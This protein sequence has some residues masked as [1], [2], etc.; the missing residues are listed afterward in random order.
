MMRRIF[1][2]PTEIEVTG[3]DSKVSGGSSAQTSTAASQIVLNTSNNDAIAVNE[4]LIIKDVPGYDQS[5]TNQTP[6]A[7]LVLVVVNRDPATGRPVCKAVNGSTTTNLVPAITLPAAGGTPVVLARSMRALSEKQLRTDS[8]TSLPTKKT[9]YLQKSACEVEA[10]TFFKLAGK[11]VELN[12]SDITERGIMEFRRENN[13]AYWKGVQKKLVLSNKYRDVAE[14]TYFTPGIFSQIPAGNE[15]DFGGQ[16][17][18]P[19]SL[20]DMLQMIFSTPCSSDTKVLAAG[21]DVI[22]ALEKTK[23]NQ[24]V[25]LTEKVDF[26][27]FRMRRLEST[28]GEVWLYHAKDLNQIG[29]S[30]TAVALDLNYIAKVEMGGWRRNNWDNVKLG[31]ADSQTVSIIE[32]SAFLLRYPD[33]FWKITL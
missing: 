22:A 18:T 13:V 8:F 11:E 14:E 4:T 7:D 2:L 15:Y 29:L 16:T 5:G 6:N 28:F 12:F 20:I 31:T 30:N 24:N 1:Y 23:W 25:Y 19:N 17:P 10:S 9:I 33:A 3:I 26:M 21:T 27:N 32:T